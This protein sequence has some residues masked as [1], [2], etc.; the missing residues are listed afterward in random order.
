MVPRGWGRW[1]QAGNVIWSTPKIE[2]QHSEEAGKGGPT[3]NQITFTYAQSCAIA[4]CEGEIYDL[5]RI[6]AN[7][8]LVYNT[9]TTA[10]EETIVNNAKFAA[11]FRLYKGTSDQ[12]PDPLIQSIAGI[13]NT[14]AYR[15]TAYIVFDNL[16]LAEFGNVLPNFEFEILGVGTKAYSYKKITHVYDTNSGIPLLYISKINP[17]AQKIWKRKGNTLTYC[18]LFGN[19]VV[20]IE[21]YDVSDD[22]ILENTYAGYYTSSVAA[23]KTDDDS[24]FYALQATYSAN[25]TANHYRSPRLLKTDG[26][27]I[28]LNKYIPLAGEYI[29]NIDVTDGALAYENGDFVKNKLPPK[30]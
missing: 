21:T 2:T 25:S 14:S 27:I 7:G 4:L 29:K 11:N 24:K 18:N 13:E 6:W 3:Q 26:K 10:D 30:D 8:K 16:Q 12:M 15:G 9:T 19:E 23:G 5:P 20:P 22:T 28:N 1:R 17:G